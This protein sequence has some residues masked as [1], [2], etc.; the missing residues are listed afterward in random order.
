MSPREAGLRSGAT[1][2]PCGADNLT[3]KRSAKACDA[4]IALQ[5]GQRS[6]GKSWRLS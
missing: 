4:C 1:A 5:V 6:C 3:G 2:A